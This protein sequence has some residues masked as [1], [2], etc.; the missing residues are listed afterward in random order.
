MPLWWTY[1]IGDL[2]RRIDGFLVAAFFAPTVFATFSIGARE[3]PLVG[4]IAYSITQAILPRISGL[5]H[6]SD[7]PSLLLT[8]HT[9]IEK[10]ALFL[11]PVFAF[12]A[13]SAQDLVILVFSPTFAAA[14][15]VFII[16]LLLLPIRLTSYGAI[17]TALG[18][19]SAVFY[20]ATLGI[21][22]NL[23]LSVFLLKTAG[24]TGPAI[25]TVI[26]QV[27]M[28]AF[29]LTVI[30]NT[31]KTTWHNLLPYR[32]LLLVALATAPPTLIGLFTLHAIENRPI[33]VL[34]AAVAFSLL[35]FAITW[36]LGLISRG[37]LQALWPR[38]MAQK[39]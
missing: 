10:T 35:Y 23:P 2:N 12:L 6:N 19:T 21:A 31:I 39:D 9:S 38:G 5:S 32:R 13:A 20:G 25:A 14:A 33:S 36:K 17:L 8:W 4:V 28:V 3:I 34:C 1:I 26:S 15:T 7:Y 27:V 16:Y 29:Y 22:V 18:K 37:D 11:F 24:W 30:R